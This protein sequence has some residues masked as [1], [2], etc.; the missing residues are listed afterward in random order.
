MPTFTVPAIFKA[1]DKITAPVRKMANTVKTFG[2][3]AQASM[4]R[5]SISMNN[6]NKRVSMVH[7]NVKS[8]IGGILGQLGRLGVGIGLLAVGTQVVNANIELDKSLASLSAITGKTGKQFEVFTKQVNQVAK[9]Q[10]IFAGDT[11]KAFEVVASAQPILLDNANALARV[12][13]AAITLSKASG[14]DLAASAQNL[15]GVM[16]QFNLAADQSERVMNALAA[17]SVAGSANITNVA[18]SMKNFGAVASGANLSVE[19][20]IAL[21]EVMGSKSIFA[22]EAGTKLRASIINLQKAGVGYQS[23]LFNMSD[24]LKEVK[25]RVDAARTAKEKDK[26]ITDIFKKTGIST[27]KIL[28]ENIDQY[29]KM[30]HAVTGTNTAVTQMNIK[31]N[32][33]ENRLKEIRDSFKNSITATGDQSK[34]M[35]WLKDTMLKVSQNMD[36]IISAVVTGIKVFAI[37][38]AATMAAVV[39]QK[40]LT[41]T[42]GVGKFIKFV[43][44]VMK[45]AKAKG[46]WTAAQWAL[47]VAMN[48]NPIFLIITAI[49]ALIAGIVALV[50]NWENIVNWLKTSDHWFAKLLRAAVYP[51]I[52]AF[53]AIG[54]IFDW[55]GEKFS[56]LINWVKTSDNWFAKM[57]R[58]SIKPL[59]AGIKMLGNVFEWIGGIFKRVWNWIKK[60]TT[61]AFKPIKDIINLFSRG[62][63]K[64]LGVDANL[65]TEIANNT[66]AR[67]VA[68]RES[69]N[70]QQIQNTNRIDL[71]LNNRTNDTETFVEGTGLNVALTGY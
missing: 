25:A 71:F 12:T 19:Q 51:F 48:A 52:Q 18:A 54:A 43:G 41:V 26:I 3:N 50:R 1:V 20:S 69:N 63:Q 10:T 33:F 22:E 70:Q 55:I 47:N 2:R 39:A 23:G 65:N 68:V 16:N 4:K 6:F 7:A 67:E 56:K 34:Q 53:K 60:F 58:F 57:I 40:A 36:K 38:K 37:Y 8:K 42:I 30:T 21:V 31:A 66:T 27:G 13:N 28:L 29:K 62:T 49:I 32:T 15:T 45:M 9:A 46:I 64:E 17:G 11:A 61:N 5:A 24:A 44:I 35:D 14:D 59:V